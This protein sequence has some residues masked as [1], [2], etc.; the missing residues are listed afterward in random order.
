MSVK[1]YMI[2]VLAAAV[3]F[4]LFVS[5]AAGDCVNGSGAPYGV[6]GQCT[7][8]TAYGYL[9]YLRFGVYAWTPET[10]GIALYGIANS[11]TGSTKGVYG[12]VASSSGTAVC[13]MA[14]SATGATRGVD[15]QCASDA[16]IGVYGY[17]YSATGAT[18]GVYGRVAS[19]SGTAVYGQAT[20]ASGTTYGVYGKVNSGDGWAGY[21]E[22]GNGLYT[23]GFRMPFGHAAGRVLTSDANGVGTWQALPAA[24]G[25]WALIGNAGTTPGTNFLGTTDDQALEL[26]VNGA[27]ALRIEPDATSPNLIGGYSGN[28]VTATVHG[29]VISGG[30]QSG[31]VNQVTDHYGV[32]GGGYNN[33]AGDG[34]GTLADRAYATVGGG[35]WNT[36]SGRAATVGGGGYNTASGWW[37]TVGGGEENTASG[38]D[39]TVGGGYDNTA[40]GL[41]ATVGGGWENT[42]SG[43][44]ATVGGG[45][46]N[47]A[48][49]EGATVGGGAHNTASGYGSFVVGGRSNTAA[50]DYSSAA[51][52]KAK[53]NH[54]GTFVW[55]DSTDAD[56]ASTAADQFSARATG[57]VRFYVS[58]AGDGLRIEPDATSPNLIGGYSGNTVTAT[59]HG[60]VIGGG[61]QSGSVNQ[62]T[63]HYGTVGGGRNNRA[64]DAAGGVDDARHA[65]VGGG[66]ANTASGGEATVGGG[67]TNIANGDY[68]TVGGGRQNT[69]SGD[70]ATV[71]GG[72]SNSASST[73]A[74]VG[75][76]WANTASGGEATV[77][78]GCYN[79]ASGGYATVG[80]GYDNRASGYEATVGGGGGNTAAGNY[81]FAAGRRAKANHQG[82]F[83][84][85]D[86]TD[87]DYASAA[88]NEFRAR[89]SG[90]V[91]FHTNAGASSGVYVAAGGGSWA[92]VSDRN[93]KQGF[94]SVQPKAV[95][96]KLV[97]TPISTWS[98][99]SE[100]GVTHMGP[101]AQDLHAA[102]GLGDS[103]RTITTIDGIGIS[104]AA[105]QGL[106]QM[107]TEV[108]A[109]NRDLRSAVEQK[110]AVISTLQSET[111]QLKQR[112][113]AIEA[114]LDALGK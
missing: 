47:I 73:E 83:V 21:F 51:G 106:Y 103:D 85:A 33:R 62:V 24:G 14:T 72:H 50:G 94:V 42:A 5:G 41:E 58:T 80:G 114:T 96:E 45:Y 105:I 29:A 71:G 84:W 11:A 98:Y 23:S 110:D 75:G 61:G 69:A 38:E 87:A 74:T 28:T 46:S 20:A 97:A 108:Q 31:N 88:A 1:R 52:R 4:G 68:A 57:G 18:K 102:Y 26:K 112:L 77:G 79:T 40:S 7:D 12:R 93:A 9:G 109:E 54:D 95:L 66:R 3:T 2:L 63:D 27:R 76:G 100:T 39:A 10:D 86:S 104:M 25:S 44:S 81:S 101:M 34:A 32:V 8:T 43:S 17:A 111:E 64:G 35:Y 99:K 92:S 78:G 19:T 53:A 67:Y 55:A 107:V 36:A 65:T 13:A 56:F 6:Y 48:S 91:Y 82:A 49:G 90:G 16:A 22:G 30:G 60:A 70:K 15:A 37:A 89:C 59:V 113:S